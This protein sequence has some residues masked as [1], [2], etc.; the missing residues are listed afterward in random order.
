MVREIHKAM[1]VIEGGPQPGMYRMDVIEHDDD[2]WLVPEWNDDRVCGVTMPARIVSLRTIP[3]GRLETPD[4]QFMVSS[5]VP[6]PVLEGRLTRDGERLYD[7]VE[8][9]QIPFP[10][11][12]APRSRPARRGLAARLAEFYL[13]RRT[14]ILTW[15][16]AASVGLLAAGFLALE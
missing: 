3:H 4:V 6:W 2:L 10:I 14:V 1:I 7:V 13:S 5:P 8:R 16:A 11:P 9:P 12:A 15:S